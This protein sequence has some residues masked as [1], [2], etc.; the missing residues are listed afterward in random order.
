MDVERFEHNGYTVRI[1]HD[2]D[3]ES[4]REWDN[5][6]TLVCFHRRYKLG[7]TDHGY[8]SDDYSSWDELIAA[9]ERD[10]KPAAIAKLGLIDHSGISIYVGGGAHSCDPGGWDSGT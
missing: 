9:I 7:D 6:A 3:A 4:P 10:H 2:E 1:I 8:N 5:L